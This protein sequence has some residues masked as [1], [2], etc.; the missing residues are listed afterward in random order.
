MLGL[1]MSHRQLLKAQGIEMN[2]PLDHSRDYTQKVKQILAGEDRNPRSRR[3]PCPWP[4][5]VLVAALTV[6]SAQVAGEVA[7]G[8]M[9]FLPSLD[10]LKGAAQIRANARAGRL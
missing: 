1:G 8:L 6:E 5:P 3:V 2:N 7:D 4:V 9:P 10:Y